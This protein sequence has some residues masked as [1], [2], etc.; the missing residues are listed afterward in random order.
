MILRTLGEAV[1]YK[2]LP[3]PCCRNTDLYVGVTSANSQGVICWLNGGGCN[4]ELSVS[5]QFNKRYK[6]V[7]D[8]ER[9]TLQEVIKRW[10]KRMVN[11]KAM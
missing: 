4:L 10:N 9:K 11:E 2:I 1:K 8:M 5:Y 3:C 6:S 7:K